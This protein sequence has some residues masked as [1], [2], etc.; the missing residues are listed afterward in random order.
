M[1]VLRTTA[2][3]LFSVLLPVSLALSVQGGD[4]SPASAPNR[5][6]AQA[7]MSYAGQAPDHRQ[8]RERPNGAVRKLA[9][10]QERLYL[11]IELG[12]G[13]GFNP[14]RPA[15]PKNN[16]LFVWKGRG[17]QAMEV[18]VSP[19]HFI[20]SRGD[21]LLVV[22]GSTNLTLGS[23]MAEIY[24]W[25]GASWQSR[26]A[27]FA[28][29]SVTAIATDRDRIWLG[30]RFPMTPGA[31]SPLVF[32]NGKTWTNSGVNL[33]FEKG[34][35]AT[36]VSALLPRGEELFLGGKFTQVGKTKAINVACMV[37]GNAIPLGSGLEDG[38][39]WEN[40]VLALAFSGTNLCAV[41]SPP[42]DRSLSTV[43]TWNGKKWTASSLPLKRVR[44]MMD[45]G[46]GGIILTGGKGLG[47]MENSTHVLRGRGDGVESMGTIQVP[48][49]TQTS[50]QGSPTWAEVTTLARSGTN[51]YAGG[52][53]VLLSMWQY[54]FVA[55]WKGDGWELVK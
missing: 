22:G 33:A 44:A 18:P 9:A 52:T 54:P 25:D 6:D 17:W 10:I 36:R 42:K 4:G 34:P 13:H 2:G 19:L 12:Q 24:G 39:L 37:G 3:S 8:L 14:G 28:C 7:L 47:I 48:L 29:L 49:V 55:Q 26:S 27:P 16:H 43:W 50:M 35:G 5:E 20:H 41:S 30:G 31:P 1:K 46:S 32:W 45:D 15:E 53:V 40:G 23:G 51:L 38:R 21:E 11:L